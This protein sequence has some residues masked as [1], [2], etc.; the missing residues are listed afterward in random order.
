MGFI[1]RGLTGVDLEVLQREG[2]TILYNKTHEHISQKLYSI[3]LYKIVYGKRLVC[4]KVKQKKG[5]YPFVYYYCF[6]FVYV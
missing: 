4:L 2:G 1:G 5:I 3:S 6:F